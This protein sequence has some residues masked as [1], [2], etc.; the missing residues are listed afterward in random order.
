M[1][2]RAEIQKQQAASKGGRNQV[3]DQIKKLEEQVKSRIAEQ[4]LARGKVAFRSAEDVDREIERLE[5]QVDSGSMKL[6]DERKA[7]TEISNLR[8]QKKGFAGFEQAQAGIDDLKKKIKDLRDGLDDPAAKALSDRYSKI[9]A[10]LDAIKAEQ[11]EAY[12]N[13]NALRD[14]RTKLHTEQQEKYLAIKKLKDDYYTQKKAFGNWEFEARQKARER[15]RAER[16]AFDKQKR[17]ERAEK[18]L[19]EASYPAYSEEIRRAKNLVYFL[20]PTSAPP[21]AAPLV[22]PSKFSA[23]PQRKV[24]DSD[25]KGVKVLRKED[26]EEDYFKGT[27]GKKGKK[28]R[29]AAKDDSPATT[30]GTSGRAGGF[31]CPPSVIEDCGSMGIDPPMVASEVPATLE[32]VKEKLAFWEKDQEAQTQRVSLGIS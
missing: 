5:K 17:K 19:E 9:T 22:A 21:S 15:A 12:K 4:K 13:I 32:K 11:D 31:M 2:E 27:G 28:G 3:M 6:V 18:A 24:D 8:K 26:R 29:K 7:L 14:E 25:L 10:E 1:T 20:D 30:P 23:E 16:E